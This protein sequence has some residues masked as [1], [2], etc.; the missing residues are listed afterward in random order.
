MRPLNEMSRDQT[1]SAPKP[2]RW[3]ALVKQLQSNVRTEPCNRRTHPFAHLLTLKILIWHSN[4]GDWQLRHAALTDQTWF[5][6]R[7]CERERVSVCERERQRARAPVRWKWAEFGV[8]IVNL[9]VTYHVIHLSDALCTLTHC[10]TFALSHTQTHTHKCAFTHI[11]ADT[12]KFPHTMHLQPFQ[13]FIPILGIINQHALS[14]FASLPL[15]VS[16]FLDYTTVRE[17]APQEKKVQASN[18]FPPG[19][20]LGTLHTWQPQRTAP[21]LI[22]DHAN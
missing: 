20:H 16:V 5:T 18:R 21:F 1:E 10:F 13:L 15:L 8:R 9:T 6:M 3:Q 2:Q 11:H 17:A 12:H 22:A 19:S 14:Y 4:A 7:V